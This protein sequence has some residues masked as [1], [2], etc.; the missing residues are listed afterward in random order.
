MTKVLMVC[1]GNICRSPLAEGILK[2]KTF[3]KGVS[4]D[5]AGTSSYHIGNT[6][7]MRSVEIAKKHNIDITNQRGRKFVISDFD[8]FDIIYAMDSLN[9]RTI[10]NLAR[11]ESDK[12]KVKIILNE[13]FPNENLDVPD[14]YNGGEHGFR[15]VYD[16]LDQV[17]DEIV[18]KIT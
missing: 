5:S 13:L 15:V 3:L 2:A 18:K 8:E 17:C 10:L 11:N 14:P 16:M 9:Y 6:P 1:L 4:V 12:Q 7:D